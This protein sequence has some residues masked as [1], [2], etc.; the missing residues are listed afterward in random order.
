MKY[1]LIAITLVAVPLFATPPQ[2]CLTAP[3]PHIHVDDSNGEF[4]PSATCPEGWAVSITKK[5]ADAYNKV[6]TQAAAIN[7]LAD[8]PCVR[9]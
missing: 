5:A 7:M 4:N 3:T 6:L 2:P 9:K 1:S 8:A